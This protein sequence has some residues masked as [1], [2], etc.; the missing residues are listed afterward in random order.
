MGE[1]FG[2]GP[3]DWV[4]FQ[5]CTSPCAFFFVESGS[6]TF[7]QGGPGHPWSNN[8]MEVNHGPWLSDTMMSKI[9]LDDFAHLNGIKFKA[10]YSLRSLKSNSDFKRPS[11]FHINKGKMYYVY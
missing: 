11:G 3:G 10:V 9:I 5:L 4:Q 8:S 2:F 1:A 6:T 7:N